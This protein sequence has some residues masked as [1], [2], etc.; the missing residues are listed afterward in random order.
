MSSSWIRSLRDKAAQSGGSKVPEFLYHTDWSRSLANAHLSSAGTFNEGILAGLA[1]PG[2]VTAMAYEPVQG[3]L[4]VGTTLGTI[5][6]FGS[7]PVQLSF[8]LKPAQKVNHLAFKS[9]TGLLICI[10]E[11]DNISIYDLTRPDPQIRA[12]YGSSSNQFRPSSASSGHSVTGPPH[13]DT[14]QRVGAHTVRNKVICIEVSNAHSHM[15]LG[16]RDGTVDTFDLERICHSAYRISNLWWEEE[17]ILRK[18]G[19]PDAPNRRHVPL[20]I[21]IKTHPKDINQLLLAYEGGAILLDVR[22]RAVLKTFQLRLLPGALGAGGK[23][24]LIWTERASPTTCI[25]W[26]PDGEVFA[27]GHE[28]GCISFWHIRDGDKPIMVRTLDS[29]DVER[30][31]T[32]PALM[33]VSRP[34]KEPIFKLAW[35]GFPE[36]SWIDMASQSAAGWQQQRQR[37]SSEPVEMPVKGTVLT[38]LGGAKAGLDPPGL[39]CANLPPY[40]ATL[41]L[42]GSGTVDANHKQRVALHDSLVPTFEVVYPTSSVVEDFLLLPKSNPHYSGSYDPS[43]VVVLLAADS[44]LPTLPPPAA[45]RGLA[46]FAFPPRS[47]ASTPARSPPPPGQQEGRSWNGGAT[48]GSPSLS[49]QQKELHLPLP[50]TLAGGGAILGAKLETLTTHAYRKLVGPL[51]VTGFNQ[52]QEQ[53]AAASSLRMSHNDSKPPLEL[54]GGKAS[55]CLSGEGTDGIPELLRG[56]SFRILLTW[57]LDGTVRFYDASPHL[58]LMGQVDEGDLRKHLA[59]PR[60]WLQSGFPSPLPHLTI[61]ARSLLHSPSM[62]GHPSFDRARGRARVQDVQ[63]AAEVLEATVALSTGQIL[64][65][66]FGFAQLSETETINEEVEEEIAREEA[67]QPNFMIPPVT[68][69]RNEMGRRSGSVSNSRSETRFSVSLASPRSEHTIE[70]HRMLDDE[71]SRAMEELDVGSSDGNAA[72]PTTSHIPGIDMQTREDARIPTGVPPPRPRRDPKRAS[73]RNTDAV[74][75]GGGL[76]GQVGTMSLPPPSGSFNAPTAPTPGSSFAPPPQGS[77]G[78]PRV[79][80]EHEEIVFL[81][82]LADP[83]Y[84]GFKPNLMVDPMRGE[85]SA[86]ASSDIG[87]LAAA[88]GTALAVLDFRSAELILKEGF[89]GETDMVHGDNHDAKALRKIMEAESRS[90][91]VHLRFSVCR[92]VEDPSLAPRLVVI[93]ANGLT[94]VWTL[95]KTLEMWLMERTSTHKLEELSDVRATHILDVHGRARLSLPNNLQQALREQDYG[96]TG[97]LSESSM[98]QADVL[99]GF[100]DRQITLRYGVTG[101]VIARTEIGERVLGCGVIERHPDKV[102]A[103]VTSSSI[104]LFSLPQLEPIIRLQR[105]HREAGEA[106]GARPSISFDPHGDFVEVCSS[107]DVR[108]WTTFASLRRP[109]QPNLRFID[110]A[111]STGMPVHPGVIASAAGVATSIAGWFGTKTTGVLSVGAQL[112]AALAGPNRPEPPKLGDALPPR[113][114]RPPMMPQ[115]EASVREKPGERTPASG[116]SLSA[117]Q[118]DASKAKAV[119]ASADSAW[120]QGYQNIDLLKARG[121]MMSGIEDGLTS[122]EKGASNF[123]KSTREAAIKGAAKD[124]INKIFS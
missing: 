17:E 1:L 109:G 12:A 16:L 120:T 13:P 63:F 101:S 22:E 115:T 122:L 38:V 55:A 24:E 81:Q 58:L 41:P 10:D 121:A 98:P 33:Q 100:T 88:C 82:H 15:F 96:P 36:K 112:D 113:D 78:M 103:V 85:V 35:S 80:H 86:F 99:L 21:D 87:F 32:D 51:D 53:E 105:H 25:A 50:L 65:W 60:V 84:D 56:A 68:S 77:T 106:H 26:R 69:R 59:S 42:W 28:D 44:A 124:K 70:S 90:P 31:V 93:R 92:I 37:A 97:S 114:Y 117:A 52:K 5:H 18:S 23:P 48:S 110:P 14:P 11:K 46:C 57:H 49:S 20:I 40:L 61:D 2:E 45:A 43:A 29:L 111:L 4:A 123:L 66:R 76:L 9:D 89:G 47:R 64:H 91:I 27:M 119:A 83:R 73:V 94:T 107:L 54:T 34:P 74:G 6:L 116:S 118:R 108:L 39:F 7:S 30:P 67:E 79:V 3:F 104:R 72:A 95:N 75:I 62:V 102:A 19:V 71:M 8:S